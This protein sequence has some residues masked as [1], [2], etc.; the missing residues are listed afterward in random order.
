[1]TTAYRASFFDAGKGGAAIA[2]ARAG[3]VIGGG[4]WAANRILPDFVRAA[5]RGEPVLVRN[6]QAVR[7]WQHVLEPLQGY[8]LLAERLFEKAGAF[9]GAWNFGPADADA[10]SVETIVTSFTRLWGPPAGWTRDAAAHPHE[11][12]F[13]RLDSS[14]AR[15]GLGWR[16]RLGLETALEW[17]VQWYKA[18]A[19]GG[20]AKQLSLAQIERYMGLADR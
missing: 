18:H 4:D 9:A 17:T 19:Q 16:P 13:L 11:A 6:P 3:N 5:R 12:G 2:S 8:L 20:D 14:K 15:A 1:V 10:V 7:P